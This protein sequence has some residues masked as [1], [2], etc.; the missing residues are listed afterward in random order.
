VNEDARK[1]WAWLIG[2]LIAGALLLNALGVQFESEPDN[3]STTPVVGN[4]YGQP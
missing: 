4:P 1:S 2:G 3:T